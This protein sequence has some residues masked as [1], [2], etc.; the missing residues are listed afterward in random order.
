[1]R[2]ADRRGP[3]AVC[4]ALSACLLGPAFG[5][6]WAE[7]QAALNEDEVKAAFLYN[8]G[9]FVQWPPSS[10]RQGDIVIGVLGSSRVLAVLEGIARGQ[11]ING[12]AVVVRAMGA[13]DDPRAY[14]I[15]FIGTAAA[16]R[17][18]EIVGRVHAAG[19]LT[20]GE[21]PDFLAEGG[22]VRFYVR[23]RRIRFEIDPVGAQRD[24]L[25]I[26]AQLLSL[27]AR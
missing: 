12:R 18:R 10:H 23:D 2:P 8:F 24:G 27:A 17:A 22:L 13:D 6:G 26:S 3:W 7:A 4:L 20:V 16:R 21:Q 11:Q 5:Q 1:M 14:H 9:K 25:K 15:V 19:V